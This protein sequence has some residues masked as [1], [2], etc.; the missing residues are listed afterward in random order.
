MPVSTYL[1]SAYLLNLVTELVTRPT[2]AE[3]VERAK[4]LARAG[5][6]ATQSDIQA[7]IRQNRER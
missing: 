7:A 4:T 3:V 5:G 6:G 1:L 2:M